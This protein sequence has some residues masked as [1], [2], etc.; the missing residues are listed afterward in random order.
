MSIK[1][2][3]DIWDK[4]PFLLKKIPTPGL[5]LIT[6]NKSEK[7]IMTIGWLS[8]GIVWNEPTVSILVRPSRYSYKLLEKYNEFTLNLLPDK[9]NNII[10]I[11]G[12]KSGAYCDKIKETKLTIKNSETV[13]S[14]SLKEA[15]IILE[16][17]IVYKNNINNQNLNDIIIAR[18]Y[19]NSDY[20]CIFT[21]KI[22]HFFSII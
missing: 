19:S 1:N 20:H 10:S 17:Q 22:L 12:S 18:Y 16:C 3:K 15:E 13:Q 4:I 9:F 5:L 21:A 14:V 6:G 2:A 11:C 7:N 8:F